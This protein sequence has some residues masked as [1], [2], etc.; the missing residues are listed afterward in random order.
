MD[1]HHQS[2]AVQPRVE[3]IVVRPKL[4]VLLAAPRGFCAGVRRA[5]DGVEAALER[6][7]APVYVRRP[8]VHNLA[9]VR[10]LEA[11]GA[12]FVE[13]LEEV[14]DGSVV[15]M[16][17]HGIPRHVAAE[18]DGRALTWFDAVCPLVAKVHR[19]VARHHG[20]GRHVI[21]IGHRGH[22]EIAGTLGQ[23]PAG[24]ATV[25]SSAAEV[26]AL[27][28]AADR[29]IAYAVQ[30][31]YS[32]DEAAGIIAA[33]TARF[34][35]V[36]APPRSDICY[37]TTN[38]QA[39]LRAIAAEV[40]AVIVAGAHF[41][42]NACRLAEVARAAGCPSVQFVAGPAELDFTMLRESRSLGVSAAASTPEAS[43][44]DILAALAVHFDLEIDEAAQISEQT[45]FKPLRIA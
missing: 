40:D 9:V 30:T 42:S 27:D 21:L 1:Q 2:L 25:V 18:A 15:I 33:V 8:I 28:F 44:S 5:I 12:I 24:A 26:A 14:P 19:E 35:D 32:V 10:A 43:V 38:R 22:P 17:A 13:E 23:L 37:A 45:V 29:P 36:A 6:Y 20:E 4:R 11:K 16:S 31:T 3:D 41:S 34:G 39:A 7:G